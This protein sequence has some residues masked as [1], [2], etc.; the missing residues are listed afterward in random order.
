MINN[1]S[2]GRLSHKDKQHGR[3]EHYCKLKEHLDKT[4]KEN[5]KT[6]DL[7]YIQSVNDYALYLLIS[8]LVLITIIAYLTK[9]LQLTIQNPARKARK[10]RLIT[11]K[12]RGN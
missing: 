2:N 6:N 9:I 7:Q 11:T 4:S 12:G 10:K 8:L 1:K 3:F 5:T